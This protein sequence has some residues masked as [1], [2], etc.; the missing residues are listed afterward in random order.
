M[1]LERLYYPRLRNLIARRL[2]GCI[3]AIFPVCE[4]C[5]LVQF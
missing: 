1:L 4:E 5:I 3:Y 2:S